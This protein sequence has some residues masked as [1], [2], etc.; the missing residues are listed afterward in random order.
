MCVC[1]FCLLYAVGR[2]DLGKEFLW[3]VVIPQYRIMTDCAEICRMV[4]FARH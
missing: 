2:R 1:L 3:Q 4:A